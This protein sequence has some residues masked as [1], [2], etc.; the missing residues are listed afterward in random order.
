MEGGQT[1]SPLSTHTLHGKLDVQVGK[2]S[3]PGGH[4]NANEAMKFTGHET[5][6]G[7]DEVSF[8]SS[9][10]SKP[11]T[12]KARGKQYHVHPTSETIL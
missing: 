1:V 8:S 2:H 3:T 12:P 9:G 7:T 5:I 10:G 4:R 6:I 11:S